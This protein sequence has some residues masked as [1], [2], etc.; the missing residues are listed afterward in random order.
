MEANSI[1][2][3]CNEILDLNSSKP[4]I[5]EQLPEYNETVVEN[6]ISNFLWILKQGGV[7]WIIII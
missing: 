3:N 4:T 2:S 5:T 1:N 7:I 6:K